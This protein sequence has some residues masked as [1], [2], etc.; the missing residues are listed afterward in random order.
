MEAEAYLLSGYGL[1]AA[2]EARPG[3]VPLAR[4]AKVWQPSRLK[5]IQVG[6]EFGT[7]F[8]AATQVFDL[9]PIPR[10]WLALGR[11]EGADGRFVKPGMI[12]VTCSGSVGRATLAYAPHLDMLISHDLLRVE[13]RDAK[14]WGW[15]YAYLRAPTVR[16]MMTSAQYGHMIKHLEVGHL[17]ALPLP[18]LPDAFLEHFTDRVR[19]VLELR[20]DAHAATLDAEAR[21]EECLGPL[22]PC[23]SG[24]NGFVIRTSDGLFS[25]RRRMDGLVHNPIINAMRQHLVQKGK[26][27]SVLKD[28]GFSV[29]LPGRFRRVPAEDGVTLVE[30]SDLFEIN[31]DMTK[32]IADVG[33]GDLHNGR[34]QPGWLLLARS[35][36]IY[37]VLGSLA[38]ATAA[39]DNKIVSDDVIRIAALTDAQMRPGY[40]FTALTHPTLGRM[41]LKTLAYGSSIPHIEPADLARVAVV[42]LAAT[43]EDYIA[44]RAEQAAEKRA[45]ADLLENAL[46]DEAEGI[47]SRFIA[48][49]ESGGA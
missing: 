40:V 39:Y 35:G 25:G 2:L 7:P 29:W 48:G 16:A 43:D 14:H 6:P 46:A 42:R 11:T 47:L 49:H 45:E 19:A 44:D 13:A 20:D 1:R 24:E 17:N 12:L 33:I 22:P 31:P 28:A 5:G 8:L 15:L 27:F 41:F 9:R 4:H 26:G 18:E 23:D 38:F 30:S 36:Q 32:C 21:F 34:V 10:K 3:W 37:G